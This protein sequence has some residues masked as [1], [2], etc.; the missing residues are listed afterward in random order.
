MYTVVHR[1]LTR[2]RDPRAVTENFQAPLPR[3]CALPSPGLGDLCAGPWTAP[4]RPALLS[5]RWGEDTPGPGHASARHPGLLLGAT[6]AGGPLFL[7]HGL[8]ELPGPGSGHGRPRWGPG[9]PGFRRAK[10]VGGLGSLRPPDGKEAGLREAVHPGSCGPGPP[11]SARPGVTPLLLQTASGNVE[12]KVVCF[13]R[14]RDISSTLIAL[15]DKHA[16]E[17]CPG[18]APS[19]VGPGRAPR[20]RCGGGGHLPE[21][22]PTVRLR[23]AGPRPGCRREGDLLRL[24]GFAAASSALQAGA[25]E[26]PAHP[27]LPAQPRVPPLKPATATGGRA[28]A[29]PLSQGGPCGPHAPRPSPLQ[30]LGGGRRASARGSP[31]PGALRSGLSR[32]GV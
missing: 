18:P 27:Q 31:E 6:W 7:T 26:L 14:R 19:E 20:G 24:S 13:Y 1:S 23:S 4:G 12:A 5:R 25:S 9:S 29:A 10:P 28:P 15:A 16:S 17:S 30:Q 3:A 8:R 11:G 22:R 21:V 32:L 2:G